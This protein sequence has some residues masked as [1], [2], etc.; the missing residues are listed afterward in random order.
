MDELLSALQSSKP[1]K[2]SRLD[3]LT[4]E[5]CK[6]FWKE[7]SPLLLQAVNSNLQEEQLPTTMLNGIIILIPKKI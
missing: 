3:G 7:L 5:F 2:A 4:Y 1:G 6:Q